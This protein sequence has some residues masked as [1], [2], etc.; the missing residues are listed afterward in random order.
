VIKVL[1]SGASGVV[2]YGILKS[3]KH[4]G[5]KVYLYGSTIYNHSAANVFSDEVI[6]APVTKSPNYINWLC[7]TIIENEINIIIPG[8]DD[9]MYI[10]NLNRDKINH[11]GTVILLNSFNLIEQCKDKWVFYKKFKESL[12]EY[13]IDTRLEIDGLNFPIIAKPRIGNGSRGIYK[14]NELN[15]LNDF[16]K[17]DKNKLVDYIYQ[18]LIGNDESEYSVSAFFDSNS[19]LLDFLPLKR[20]LAYSG[21]TEYAVFEDIGF[22]KV[23][24]DISNTVLPIGPTNFQFRVEQ[25]QIKLIEINPRISSATSIR[26]LY[27]FNESKLAVQYFYNGN[28]EIDI[29]KKILNKDFKVIRYLEDYIVYDCNN[30]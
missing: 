20:K 13:L 22:E 4:S 9:D 27:G 17:L 25:N 8:I 6:I 21:Y 12:S 18:P 7:E 2:G 14:L 5:L 28:I 10:W 23:I 19:K 15:E 1:V 24:A 29:H 16:L 30:K 11:L 3:L 26:T